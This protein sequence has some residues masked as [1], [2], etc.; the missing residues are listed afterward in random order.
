LLGQL[1]SAEIARVKVFSDCIL[2]LRELAAFVKDSG[3][4]EAKLATWQELSEINIIR[5]EQL[6]PVR[7]LL[8]V[9][10]SES[11]A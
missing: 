2:L 3:K 11:E 7:V 8:T 9:L 1:A 4:R 6:C 5:L 10:D